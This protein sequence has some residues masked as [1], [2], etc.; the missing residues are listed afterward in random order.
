M[1][2]S[3]TLSKK[4]PRS[5]K[6][7]NLGIF[8]NKTIILSPEPFSLCY[9][10]QIV[11]GDWDVWIRM[12][13]EVRVYCS[14]TFAF[15]Y[16]CWNKVNIIAWCSTQLRIQS[17]YRCIVYQHSKPLVIFLWCPLASKTLNHKYSILFPC[18]AKATRQTTFHYYDCNT[19]NF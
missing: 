9:S 13:I 16:C 17:K 11:F 8:Q 7:T 15:Y 1:Q 19:N 3:K 6:A 5:K 2:I 18:Y 14:S 12:L 10:Y 4:Q